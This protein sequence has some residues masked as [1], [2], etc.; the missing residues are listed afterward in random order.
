MSHILNQARTSIK[1][2]RCTRILDM[3]VTLNPKVVAE[4]LGMNA[5]GLVAYLADGVDAGWL[6][7]R[8]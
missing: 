3:I 5:R 6:S 4:A 2:L 1:R 8:A 7:D